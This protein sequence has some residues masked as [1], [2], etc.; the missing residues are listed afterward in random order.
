MDGI[1]DFSDHQYPDYP[2]GPW[3]WQ[4]ICTGIDKPS[5]TATMAYNGERWSDRKTRQV[6]RVTVPSDEPRTASNEQKSSRALGCRGK[7]KKG[8]EKKKIKKKEWKIEKMNY[9]FFRNY[10]LWFILTIL[11]WNNKNK[12]W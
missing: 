12:M 3:N 7:K 5:G 6:W 10:N 1:R 8:K 2:T 9:L 4:A 11:L